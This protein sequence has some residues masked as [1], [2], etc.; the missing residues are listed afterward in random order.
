MTKYWRILASPPTHRNARSYTLVSG[1]DDEDRN[2]ADAN[3]LSA[4]GGE[5]VHATQ[6][7][8]FA[9]WCHAHADDVR[10]DGDANEDVPSHRAYGGAH[11]RRDEAI[12]AR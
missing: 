8:L 9:H 2:G 1:A 4:H 11:E 7:T 12:Q 10:R 6:T 5:S 3:A